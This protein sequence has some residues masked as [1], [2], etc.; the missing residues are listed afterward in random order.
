ML[1]AMYAL[2]VSAAVAA[3]AVVASSRAPRAIPLR[4]RNR[5]RPARRD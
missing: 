5:R 1:V 3:L 2:A 4:V